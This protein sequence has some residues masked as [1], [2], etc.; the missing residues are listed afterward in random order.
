MSVAAETIG[1]IVEARDKPGQLRRTKILTTLLLVVFLLYTFVPLIYLVISSTKSN[2]D[3]FGTFG[4][5]FGTEFNL[6][7][8]LQALF[9]RDDGVFLRWLGNSFLYATISGLGAAILATAAGYAFAKF[10]F[11]G[12]SA[13]FALI[14]GAVMI[15]QTALVI[16]IFL[17]LALMGLS[18]NPLGVVLPSMISPIG[19]YLMR[20]YIEQAVDNELI[21]AARIDGAGEFRIF[22]DIVFRLVAPGFVTVLL[23]SFVGTWNN[24]FLPLIVLRSQEYQPITVGLA[25]WYQLA[26]QGGGGGQVLFSIIITGALVSIIPVIVV[27]LLLQRFW[28]GG[29]TAGAIK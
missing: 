24:Y 16:P 5:W 28:Q 6:F 7:E 11:P 18:N 17:L 20:V 12:R 9:A 27:F 13:G 1:V 25:T 21:D 26:Q 15:P 29:L 8:N 23:L 14:L 22:R 4:F 3:L 10:S 19:V 2:A